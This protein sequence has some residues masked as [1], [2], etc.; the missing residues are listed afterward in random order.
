MIYFD[1]WLSYKPSDI[2]GTIAQ[3]HIYSYLYWS[4]KK[5]QC[6]QEG[7]YMCAFPLGKVTC[8]DVLRT[9]AKD[10]LWTPPH[11]PLCNTKGGPLPRSL[12]RWKMTKWGCPNVTFWRRLHIVLYVTPSYVPYQRLEDVFCRH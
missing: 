10:V 4:N 7:V 2:C 8:Q 11:G 9:F 1:M 5:S 12:G 3:V 6:M